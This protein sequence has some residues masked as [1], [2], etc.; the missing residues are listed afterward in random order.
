MRQLAKRILQA[1]EDAGFRTIVAGAR[2]VRLSVSTLD[3]YEKGRRSPGAE[4]LR[5]IAKRYAVTS[6]WLLGLPQAR[7]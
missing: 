1:R 4:N 7:Q 6:D 5:Q 2:H 3:S